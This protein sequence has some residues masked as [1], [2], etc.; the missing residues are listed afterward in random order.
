M[1]AEK[2]EITVT[3]IAIVAIAVTTFGISPPMFQS[4]SQKMA[5]DSKQYFF[6]GEK[7]CLRIAA[8]SS[9][10]QRKRCCLFSPGIS[11][12]K[13]NFFHFFKIL[14]QLYIF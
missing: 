7:H 9:S 12:S 11:G 13:R 3:T 5:F 2:T 8:R 6:V 10:L 1:E 14:N 4:P